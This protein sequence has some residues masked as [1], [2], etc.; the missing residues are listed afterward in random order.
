MRSLIGGGYDSVWWTNFKGRYKTLKGGRNTKKSMDFQG[1]ECLDKIM[2]DPRRN[3]LIIRNTLKSHRTTTYNTLKQIIR[4]P[5]QSRP[6]LT[7]TPYFKFNDTNLEITYVPTGQ[8]IYFVGMD[9][10]SKIQGI[11]PEVGYMTDV[12]VEEAFQ[13]SDYESWRIVDGSIRGKLPDGLFIQITFL[14]NSWDQGHWIN[15]RFFKGRLE[16]DYEELESKGF[17]SWK[18]ESLVLEYGRGL[19]LHTSSYKINEFR[20]KEVYD[21]AMEELRRNSIEMYKVEGLGMWGNSTGATYPEWGDHLR[22]TLPEAHSKI[23]GEF[24]IGID[25]GGSNGMGRLD[26]GKRLG[27]G[28]AMI[29]SGV[30]LDGSSLIALD[31]YFQSNLNARIPKTA[32]EVQDEMISTIIRWMDEWPAL[33]RR[34]INVYV[35]CA[36]SGGFR[37]SLELEARRRGLMGV[38]FIPS[39]KIPI[40]SRV[41]FARRLMAYGDLRITDSCPNLIREIKAARAAEDGSVREDTD[42]HAQNAFEYGWA[43][44]RPMI[45]RWK[46]FK[47]PK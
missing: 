33:Q 3:A 12:Y 45:R 43:P 18:D 10:P 31:E 4:C 47:E 24:S 15:E 5:D 40:I 39:T 30:T 2:T 27:Q 35:D 8:K 22:M 44:L 46:T 37:Q 6:W 41:Y 19:A 11:R 7:L 9:D 28:N 21:A 23:F 32:P 14:L 25:F 36:D 29:L 16:D 26:K 38:A 17:Q 1:Y 13:L 20:D 34:R 42:D